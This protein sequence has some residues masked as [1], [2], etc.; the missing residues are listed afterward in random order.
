MV[1]RF[2]AVDRCRRIVFVRKSIVT[3]RRQD[4]R[5]ERGFFIPGCLT[6]SGFANISKNIASSSYRVRISNHGSISNL[7]RLDVC[8]RSF[9]KIDD[10]GFS[11]DAASF[12]Q[13]FE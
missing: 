3:C 13:G 1:W 6:D 9:S 4:T 7:R 8:A 12:L 2:S 10:T 5:E 11:R